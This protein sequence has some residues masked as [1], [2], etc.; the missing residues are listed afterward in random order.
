MPSN[1]T[2]PIEYRE[3][4]EFP[5][6]RVGNDGSVW[7]NRVL[8]GKGR[9]LVGPWKQLKPG[10]LHCGHVYVNLRN[11]G[12]T[13]LRRVHHLVLEAFVTPRPSGMECRHFPDRNP[14]NNRLEN[15]QWGT[16]SENG[17][18]KA[19]HGTH[20]R[21]ERGSLAKLK[22]CDVRQIRLMV[23]KGESHQS[24]ANRFHVSRQTVTDIVNG[25]TWNHLV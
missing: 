6:Y 15:L 2:T 9:W 11:D 25:R 5:G 3:I 12:K 10:K 22:E 19:V 18:D 4:S 1:S 8:A 7:S 13:H 20:S 23:K 24:V 21:G 17:M 16:R 14:A